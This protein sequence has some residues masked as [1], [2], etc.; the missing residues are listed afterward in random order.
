MFTRGVS[1][2]QEKQLDRAKQQTS[3][4]LLTESQD[5][6]QSFYFIF[7]RFKPLSDH[8]QVNKMFCV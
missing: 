3:K 5:N 4:V 7:V 6:E 1:T 2:P 8:K